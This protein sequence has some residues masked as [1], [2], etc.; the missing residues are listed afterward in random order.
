LQVPEQFDIFA[1]PREI[2]RLFGD[3]R[4]PIVSDTLGVPKFRKPA[5]HAELRTSSHRV[6]GWLGMRRHHSWERSRIPICPHRLHQRVRFWRTKP[7]IF[8][9]ASTNVY[10][11]VFVAKASPKVLQESP[12]TFPQILL[13]S[14]APASLPKCL[15]DV[16]FGWFT[17]L[18][19]GHMSI[20]GFCVFCGLFLG[21]ICWRVKEYLAFLPYLW[22]SQEFHPRI[23]GFVWSKN[24]Q[25]FGLALLLR[26]KVFLIIETRIIEIYRPNETP[27]KSVPF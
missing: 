24:K 22:C 3:L 13:F 17:P 11:E 25:Y 2:R 12:Q 7:N 19:L 14:R 16:E 27:I 5:R 20:S 4:K 18:T 9:R 26:E 23:C 21:P 1:H 6:W 8:P 10:V 15:H